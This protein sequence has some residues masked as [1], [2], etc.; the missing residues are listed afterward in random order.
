MQVSVKKNH[1][2]SSWRMWV[3]AIS[4]IVSVPSL[5]QDNALVGTWERIEVGTWER[6][7]DEDGVRTDPGETYLTFRTDGRFE[8]VLQTGVVDLYES[9]FG[10]FLEIGG[11]G[12]P[13]DIDALGEG[14]IEQTFTGT[15]QVNGDVLTITFEEVSLRIN[16]VD[17]DEFFEMVEGFETL[18]DISTADFV[19]QFR[20][21]LEE[22]LDKPTSSLV[23]IDGDTL[24]LIPVDE[25]DPLTDSFKENADLSGI[26]VSFQDV[27]AIEIVLRD[28]SPEDGEGGAAFFPA[29]SDIIITYLDGTVD[30]GKEIRFEPVIAGGF[31]QQGFLSAD[32]TEQISLLYDFASADFLN[33]AN[34]AKEEIKKVEFELVLGND[35][36]IEVL[37]FDLMGETAL[38]GTAGAS[39][40]IMD[41]TNVAIIR[42]EVVEK[43][44]GNETVIEAISWGQMKAGIH[45]IQSNAL[46]SNQQ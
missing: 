17:F 35:Y 27:Q 7:E 25:E 6:I 42:I 41:N 37:I 1:A 34:G 29:G 44:Q 9:L 15:W 20:A 32:G 13:L 3:V 24:A 33:R 5:A 45:L 2:N 39:G 26:E 18:F 4:V 10:F 12:T 46:D 21:I 11:L 28:D 19:S 40:N 31:V 8:V 16:G 22:A 36:R 30:R 23:S 38:V 43:V 14:T